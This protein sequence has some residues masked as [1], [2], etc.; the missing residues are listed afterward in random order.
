M[1]NINKEKEIKIWFSLYM[2]YNDYNRLHAEL[3]FQS[4]GLFSDSVTGEDLF[5]ENLSFIHDLLQRGIS[6]DELINEIPEAKQHLKTIKSRRS[7]DVSR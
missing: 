5:N 7:K 1:E 4:N 2:T 3:A 6:E